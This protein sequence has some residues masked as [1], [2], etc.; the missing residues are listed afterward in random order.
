MINVDI[1]WRYKLMFRVQCVDNR[2]ALIK[3]LGYV[4]PS[5]WFPSFSGRAARGGNLFFHS[6]EKKWI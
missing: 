5:P 4:Y 2:Q 3:A 6:E 1:I